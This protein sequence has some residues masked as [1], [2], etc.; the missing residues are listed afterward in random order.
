VKNVDIVNGEKM[1][2][3]SRNE[4]MIKILID[5]RKNK[6]KDVK[7]EE[8]KPKNPED[9]KNLLKMWEESKKEKKKII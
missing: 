1:A 7:K 6:I 8:I 4:R 5:N 2:T 3:P 9:I